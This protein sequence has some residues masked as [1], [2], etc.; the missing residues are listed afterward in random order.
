M[1][2]PPQFVAR[3]FRRARAARSPQPPQRPR[4]LA[5]PACEHA[6]T[7]VELLVVIAIIGI[8]VALLLPAIQAAREAAR[9]MTCSNNLKNISL[10]CIEF[11]DANKRLPTSISQWDEDYEW[12]STGSAPVWIG[13]SNMQAKAAEV[14]GGPGRNGKGWMVDILPNMEEQSAYDQIVTHYK[15]DYQFAEPDAGNGM[16]H[17][18]I[19]EIMAT[20]FSWLSCPSDESARPAIGMFYWGTLQP[21]MA[22]NKSTSSYK[23]V[24]GDT[25]ICN[26]GDSN[27]RN[28][29]STPFLDFGSRPDNH[30]KVSANGLL[31]RTT[32]ARPVSLQKATDG[33]SK[34]FLVGE[35][36][37]SQDPHSAAF[38][39]D[40]DWGTCGI[41]LNYFRFPE[42]ELRVYWYEMRGFK[43]LHSG[44]AQFVMADGSVHFVTET[45]DHDTYRGICTRNGGETASL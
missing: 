13:P 1:R 33:V 19:R 3:G 15:G 12:Q 16:S 6:F 24:I 18:A 32:Y 39:A 22:V 23:G 10:A 44:G 45:I 11:H 4:R 29:A 43:S 42:S 20:Q 5:G 25:I 31:F 8:L 2:R 30:D 21:N 41:P 26:T 35:S 28:C 27:N 40:G 9:R 14:N 36:L 37:V 34:T 7:L 17:M 38:F